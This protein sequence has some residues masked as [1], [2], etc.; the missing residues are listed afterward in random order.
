MVV[1]VPARNEER[2]IARTLAALGHQLGEHPDRYRVVVLAN[3]CTDGTAYEAR[4]AAWTLPVPVEVL[5]ETTDPGLAHVGHARGRVLT[6][7]AARLQGHP[8]GVLATT[9]ADTVAAPDWAMR[10][11]EAL[12]YADVVGGRILT[13][14]DE[15][16]DLPRPLRRLQLQDAAYH[17]LAT[18]LSARLDPEPGDPWPRHHQHFGANL[19]LRLS[20]W[21]R[22]PAWPQVRSLEDVA[23]VHELQRLDLRVRHC[24]LA[25]VWTSVRASG[26]VEV[27]LSSQLREWQDLQQQGQTWLVPGADELHAAALAAAALRRAWTG[28]QRLTGRRVQRHLAALWLTTPEAMVTALTAPTLGQASDLALSA[29]HQAGAWAQRFPPVALGEALRALRSMLGASVPVALHLE[30]LHLTPA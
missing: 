4:R 6:L 30:N 1:A 3:N 24:P 18:Q 22:V 8:S 9:D 10:L 23:L 29:R 7:A 13:L 26:R 2:R 21:E 11:R 27:G 25:R 28:R 15:R 20:A 19:A 16:S 17:L 14:P 5:E 12:C